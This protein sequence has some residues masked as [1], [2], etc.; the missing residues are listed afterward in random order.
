[1]YRAGKTIGEGGGKSHE[2][3]QFQ[4]IF[5]CENPCV[6]SVSQHGKKRI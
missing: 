4:L 3:V 2:C 5:T 1:M 6:V